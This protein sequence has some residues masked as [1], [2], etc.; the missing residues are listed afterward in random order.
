MSFCNV[1]EVKKA[2]RNSG[3]QP[4]VTGGHE[5]GHRAAGGPGSSVLRSCRP[6]QL[7]RAPGLRLDKGDSPFPSKVQQSR[8]GFFSG[9]SR[10]AENQARHNIFSIQPH[11]LQL[12]RNRANSIVNH[13]PYSLS[14]IAPTCTDRKKHEGRWVDDGNF[15]GLFINLFQP[16]SLSPTRQSHQLPVSTN[17]QPASFNATVPDERLGPAP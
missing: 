12:R 8:C 17:G 9:C 7:V 3:V 10:T 2:G 1:G 14:T 15:S 11:T 16:F 13:L 6:T 4:A 5:F